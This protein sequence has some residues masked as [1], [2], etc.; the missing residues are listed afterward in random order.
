M[1]PERYNLWSEGEYTYSMAFGFIPNIRSYLHEDNKIRPCL[2]IVPGGGY[3]A[4]SPTEGEIVARDFVRRGYNAFVLTYTTNFL[5]SVPLGFQPMKDLSRAIRYIRKRAKEFNVNE[6][7]IILCGFSAGGHLCGSVCVHYE[8]ILDENG[9]YSKISNRPDAAILS[10]PVITSGKYAHRGS[11]R[12]LLGSEP[13]KEQLEYMSLE[14]HVKEDTPPCFLWQ[15][16]D[17]DTVPVEN[18]YLYAAACR[19]K[20]VLYAQHVFS[21]GPHGMST[22]DEI[23]AKGQFGDSYT[24]EQITRIMEKVHSGELSIPEEIQNVLGEYDGNSMKELSMRNHASEEV[25]FWKMLADQWVRSVL[26][27]ANVMTCL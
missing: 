8:D 6:N 27:I 19:E 21:K 25:A 15:T 10:Y 14:K 13:L 20:H 7:Q 11:F 4:V 5:Q 12:A 16:A 24:T 2:L 9:L 26:N 23:W 17:D 22:A 3:T 18:S 1:K